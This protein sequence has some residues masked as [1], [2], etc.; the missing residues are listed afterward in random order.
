MFFFPGFSTII[1]PLCWTLRVLFGRCIARGGFEVGCR[2]QL[3]PK[4]QFYGRRDRGC[5]ASPSMFAF[6]LHPP[7]PSIG[8][9][10]RDISTA[11]M[12]AAFYLS[13]KCRVIVMCP[14]KCYEGF[15]S[16]RLRAPGKD[17]GLLPLARRLFCQQKLH[18]TL[19]QPQ[20][21]A[22]G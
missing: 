7:G 2:C 4:A 10:L 16:N 9:L 17:F 21:L 6:F 8:G 18:D 5:P 1:N 19:S 3:A 12:R 20:K 13:V 22:V 15:S 14:G 11:I